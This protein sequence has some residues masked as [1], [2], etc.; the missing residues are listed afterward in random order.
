LLL[1][2]DE[3]Q[4]AHRKEA[5]LGVVKKETDEIKAKVAAL[6]DELIHGEKSGACRLP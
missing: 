1:L 3:V 2:S 4:V 6:L 5:E